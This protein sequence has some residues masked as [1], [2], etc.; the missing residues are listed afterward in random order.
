MRIKY[1]KHPS[2]CINH[3][4]NTMKTQILTTEE[5]RNSQGRDYN[6]STWDE[7]I[8]RYLKYKDVIFYVSPKSEDGF[9][10][11]RYFVEYTLDEGLRLF[12]SFGYSE[13]LTSGGFFRLDKEFVSEDGKTIA[14][15][16]ELA[17]ADK[18][19]EAIALMDYINNSIFVN[20]AYGKFYNE[21]TDSMV[22]IGNCKESRDWMIDRC[23]K[24]GLT[25][26]KG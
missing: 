15:V 23:V 8:N 13:S 14:D 3:N 1:P 6:P 2:G 24:H 16:V 7:K 12:K 22:M 10:Y 18:R 25:F 21:E 19:D 17:K 9:D 4:L 5:I 26:T 20:I 11:D